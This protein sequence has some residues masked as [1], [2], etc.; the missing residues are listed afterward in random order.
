MVGPASKMSLFYVRQIT[1]S[2]IHLQTIGR[3][4]RRDASWSINQVLIKE[5][6][7]VLK[8]K[9]SKS[10]FIYIGYD[11]CWTFANGSLNPDLFFLDNVHLVEKENLK[12]TDQCSVQSKLATGSLVTNINSFWYPTKR[13]VFYIKQLWLFPVIFFYCI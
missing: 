11:S 10:F 7:Q 1:C 12:L 13:C 6:K 9:C 5:I 3:I 8:A 2:K 4:L